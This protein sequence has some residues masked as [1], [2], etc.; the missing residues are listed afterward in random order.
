[1][2]NQNCDQSI[3]LCQID[4]ENQKMERPS[5]SDLYNLTWTLYLIELFG[6]ILIALPID[7][8]LTNIFNKQS[9]GEGIVLF[10]APSILFFYL[11]L[12]PAL[13]TLLYAIF[14][15]NAF[16]FNW[17]DSVLVFLI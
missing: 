7:L 9:V 4:N 17:V 8:V 1:M 6:P 15:N 3:E 2:E 14:G 10:T 5:S 12:I 13:L 11:Y 16:I